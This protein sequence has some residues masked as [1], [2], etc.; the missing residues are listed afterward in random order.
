MENNINTDVYSEAAAK[1]LSTNVEQWVGFLDDIEDLIFETYDPLNK[2]YPYE[3]GLTS[4]T[5]LRTLRKH[6]VHLAPSD[7]RKRLNLR[8][9]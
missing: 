6:M 5:R 1:E 7:K 8:N 9:Y 4:L 3:L 2:D